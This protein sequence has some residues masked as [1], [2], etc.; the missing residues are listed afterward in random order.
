[1]TMAESGQAGMQEQLSPNH[2]HNHAS[3]LHHTGP[4]NTGPKSSA[5]MGM[6]GPADS[7]STAHEHDSA[8]CEEHC[9]SC[10]N[11]CS[12]IAIVSAQGSLFDRDQL[13]DRFLSGIMLQ[14]HDT[15]FRPPIRA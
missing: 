7:D 4:D 15:P 8:D 14:H 13:S 5:A 6:A 11:H 9:A 2:S 3:Q 12:S 10:S 1:M